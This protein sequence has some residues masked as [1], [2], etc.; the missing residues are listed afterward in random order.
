MKNQDKGQLPSGNQNN[1]SSSKDPVSLNVEEKWFEVKEEYRRAYPM[2]TDKDLDF[3]PG[4]FSE[5]TDRIASKTQR[6]R[7]EVNNEIRYWNTGLLP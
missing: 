1:K 6:C 4:K 5:M 7:S 3:L 2:L